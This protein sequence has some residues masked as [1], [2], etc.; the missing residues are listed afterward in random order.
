MSILSADRFT[1]DVPGACPL[2]VE[3]R[4]ALTAGLD[5]PGITGLTTHRPACEP[6]YTDHRTFYRATHAD[7]RFCEIGGGGSRDV[8]TVPGANSVFKIP[9]NTA[10][11]SKINQLEATYY[12]Q[13]CFYGHPVVPCLLFWTPT[14]I[15]VVVMEKVTIVREHED[16]PH[17]AKNID[18]EQVAYSPLL[19]RWACYDAG[20]PTYNSDAYQFAAAAASTA[21]LRGIIDR[22][23]NRLIGVH[24]ETQPQTNPNNTL[25]GCTG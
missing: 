17:W 11:D 12:Q 4:I 13:G 3:Q 14:G 15:P 24:L 25:T 23:W 7:R 9:L 10:R 18:C 21:E 1:H 16:A 5:V 2:T 6:S 20:W 19:G 8:F 22:E